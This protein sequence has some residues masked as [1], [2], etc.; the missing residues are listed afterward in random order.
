MG[1]SQFRDLWDLASFVAHGQTE[2]NEFIAPRT[3]EAR[4]SAVDD[5]SFYF[6]LCAPCHGD[7]GIDMRTMPRE[8]IWTKAV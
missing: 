4:G 6:A 5:E 7:T 1:S 3:K 8:N 2:M